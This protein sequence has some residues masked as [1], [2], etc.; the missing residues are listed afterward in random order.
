MGFEANITE[1]QT[2]LV[3]DLAVVHSI[4]YLLVSSGNYEV[5]NVDGNK[6]LGGDDFDNL[7]IGE[8]LDLIKQEQVRIWEQ[9]S[10]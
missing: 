1:P 4:F 9:M 3:Y 5:L 7:I 8:M 2:I 10:R 6:L